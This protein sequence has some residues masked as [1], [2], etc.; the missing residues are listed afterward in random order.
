LLTGTP[1]DLKS[2]CR[3]E[4]RCWSCSQDRR[5]SEKPSNFQLPTA[6]SKRMRFFWSWKLAVDSSRYCT[7]IVPFSLASPS[8][9]WSWYV[10]TLAYRG[11]CWS[12]SR[13]G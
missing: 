2:S 8:L 6:T 7:R 12:G 3:V 9:M 10:Q 5:R 13:L 1:A 4:S 11:Y